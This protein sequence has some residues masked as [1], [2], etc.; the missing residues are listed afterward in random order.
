M[1]T[2]LSGRNG[3]RQLFRRKVARSLYSLIPPQSEAAEETGDVGKASRHF[4]VP[5]R[6]TCP[7]CIVARRVSTS[8]TRG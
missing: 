1:I 2:N 7:F 4:A 6:I 5:T 8:G 3:D